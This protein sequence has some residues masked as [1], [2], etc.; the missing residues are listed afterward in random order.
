M[1]V[2]RTLGGDESG[3]FRDY[4]AAKTEAV[5]V[6]CLVGCL[7]WVAPHE[8]PKF[9][10]IDGVGD[11]CGPHESEDEASRHA[12]GPCEWA[13]GHDHSWPVYVHELGAL[14]RTVTQGGAR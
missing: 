8:N 9:V 12:T 1:W 6:G 4:D 10:V 13:D 11:V 14:V 2:V 3:P 7:A 5:Y